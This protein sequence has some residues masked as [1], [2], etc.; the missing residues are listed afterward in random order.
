MLVDWS[1]K[2]TVSGAS[3]DVGAPVK[4]ATGGAVGADVEVSK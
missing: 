4:S 3:P 2:A 1:V